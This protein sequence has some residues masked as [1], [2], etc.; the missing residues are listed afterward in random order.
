MMLPRWR[1]A[2]ILFPAVLV[3]GFESVRHTFFEDLPTWGGNAAAGGVAVLGSAVYWWATFTLI[4][5]LGRTLQEEQARRIELRERERIARRLHESVSQALFFLNVELDGVGRAL[6]RGDLEAA[7]PALAEAK[8]AVRETYRDVRES[9]DHLA[10]HPVHQALIPALEEAIT[11]LR[12]QTGMTASLETS[13]AFDLPAMPP[14][15]LDES[16]GIVREALRNVRKHAQ[17]DRVAV[18]V[19]ADGGDLTVSIRDNGRGLDVDPSDRGF[20]LYDMRRR[21]TRMGGT[22]GVS[23]DE[24]GTEVIL[25]LPVARLV[26]ER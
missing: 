25:R 9:I 5:R 14:E 8:A 26:G 10:R 17:A 7:A 1:W 22:L 2:W 4:G 19:E 15:I 21:A 18:R 12:R 6:E 24:G 13:E 23:S 11:E 3:G 20:G 16:M